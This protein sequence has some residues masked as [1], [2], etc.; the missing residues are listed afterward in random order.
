[1]RESELHAHIAS[2]SIGLD[3]GGGCEVIAGPGD[4]CAIVRSSNGSTSFL[5]VDQL[6]EGRHFEP[7][8]PVDLIARK[9][10]ARSVSD[11]AAM[12]G[13][14]A[15]ALASGTLCKD[16]PHSNELFDAMSRWA[17][18][19][20]CPLVGGDIATHAKTDSPMV[21]SVTIGGVIDAGHT[22]I[23]RSG[24]KPGDLIYISG[25]IGASF[26]TG[27][28]LRFDPRIEL[29]RWASR[30]GSGVHAMMDLSDGLG[31]DCDRI[32]KASQVCIEISAADVPI[33]HSCEGWKRAF[34]DGEDYELILS[35]DPHA[36]LPPTSPL[37]IGPI[38][39]VRVPKR[40]ESAGAI[41]VAP[42]GHAHG[43]QELGWDH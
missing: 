9:S 7:A 36:D 22:P 20:G 29:G 13:T 21:L 25:P 8:T 3:A 16:Y 38:G 32:A 18:H 40:K 34:S 6:V 31:R 39:V 5:T 37:L 10:I 43:G 41:I 4:D 15:W 33:H 11:I 24:A 42:D 23:L 27:H 14:P 17:K 12:G 26:E 28:H 35:I 2:R 30:E 1:M 19:W